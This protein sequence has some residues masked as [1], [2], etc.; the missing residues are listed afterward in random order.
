MVERANTSVTIRKLAAIRFVVI[1]EL[2]QRIG[3]DRRIYS[4]REGRHRNVG[5]R[6]KVSYRIVKRPGFEDCFGDVSARTHQQDG[7]AV[8]LG[9]GDSGWSKRTAP[10]AII[11]NNDVSEQRLNFLRPGAA[12][13]VKSTA[14][15]K[16]NDQ[17][18][19]P[20]WIGPLRERKSRR[21]PSTYGGHQTD[22]QQVTSPHCVLLKGTPDI[23]KGCMR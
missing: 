21:K 8:R 15:R 4:D 7:L 5:N 16:R 17:S 20:G 23:P 9:K 11:L 12:Y 6:L 3:R 19:G 1:D 13:R 18:D 22:C 2:L 10:T 14:R